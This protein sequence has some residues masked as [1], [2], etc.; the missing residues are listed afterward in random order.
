MAGRI[1]SRST[2]CGND[3][4]EVVSDVINYHFR[5]DLESCVFVVS[6]FRGNDKEKAERYEL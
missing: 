2:D 1:D 5:F 4:R 6:H 3:R